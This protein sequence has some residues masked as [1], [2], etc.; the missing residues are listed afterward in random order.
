MEMKPY[1]YNVT[2]PIESKV[3]KEETEKQFKTIPKH[4]KTYSPKA[5]EDLNKGKEFIRKAYSQESKKNVI[6]LL[7]QAIPNFDNAIKTDSSLIEAYYLAG[8]LFSNQ[9]ALN[10]FVKA[11]KYLD[12][13]E[14]AIEYSSND[15]CDS[16]SNREML[17]AIADFYW[18]QEKD[19]E[20]NSLKAIKLYEKALSE[21]LPIQ[22]E[23]KI[24]NEFI[25]L[26]LETIYHQLAN[27]LVIADSYNLFSNYYFDSALKYNNRNSGY[28]QKDLLI[29]KKIGSILN[30][31][32]DWKAFINLDYKSVIY[33]EGKPLVSNNKLYLYHPSSLV[34]EKNNIIRIWIKEINLINIDERVFDDFEHIKSLFEFDLKNKKSRVLQSVSYYNNNLLRDENNTPNVEWEYI[35]PGTI[36]ETMYDYL[37]KIQSK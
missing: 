10:D 14:K 29:D 19:L 21:Q 30:S 6:Q 4:S 18:L 17:L 25:Y 33:R 9:F 5:V 7:K 28:R 37:K 23:Y 24:S 27:F 16:I 11:T 1:V 13:V 26:R 12:E 34:K 31:N 8:K 15:V 22:I 2:V 35:V 20:K 32:R 36:G 3:Q